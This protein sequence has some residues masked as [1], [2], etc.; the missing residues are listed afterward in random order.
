M[1]I[2][3]ISWWPRRRK[4]ALIY[5]I[6]C[7]KQLILPLLSDHQALVTAPL[8][9]LFELSIWLAKRVKRKRANTLQLLTRPLSKNTSG[10]TNPRFSD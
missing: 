4:I 5:W 9:I 8:I 1:G 7:W 6:W 10:N 3:S 2:I